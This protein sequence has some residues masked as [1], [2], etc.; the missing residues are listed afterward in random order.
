MLATQDNHIRRLEGKLSGYQKRIS[1]DYKKETMTALSNISTAA[2]N[3][4]ESIKSF[5][6]TTKDWHRDKRLNKPEFNRMAN[7]RRAKAKH[8]AKN[9]KKNQKRK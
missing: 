6:D 5:A 4:G 2:T 7:K 9:R 1:L 3:T 8:D